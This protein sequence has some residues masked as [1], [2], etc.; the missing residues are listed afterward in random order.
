LEPKKS[1][2]TQHP[3]KEQEIR[4]NIEPIEWEL[5]DLDWE[6]PDGVGVEDA[7]LKK[8]TTP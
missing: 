3:K 6:V 7:P 5:P 4:W 1:N 2:K 8:N